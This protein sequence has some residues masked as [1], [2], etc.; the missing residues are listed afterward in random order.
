MRR[1]FRW[2]LTGLGVTGTAVALTAASALT[3]QAGAGA[4]AGAEQIMSYRVT[5][6]IH[7]DAS[8]VV[9]EQIVYDFGRYERHGL[10][11]EIPVLR[12]YS[13]QYDRYYP[14]DIRSVSSPDAPA[15]YTLERTADSVILKIG[16]PDRTVTGT[17]TYRLSYVVDGALN[18]FATNDELYWDAV[19][20]SWDV[21]IRQAAVR[22]T[23]PAPPLGSGCWA[24]P[25]GS[26][27]ACAQAQIEGRSATFAQPGLRPHEGLTIAVAL[28]K[29][30]VAAPHPVLRHRWSMEQAF[31]FTPVTLGTAGGLLA[32]LAILGAVVLTRGRRRENAGPGSGPP[33]GLAAPAIEAAPP[34]DL[35]PGLAGTL[36]DG[37]ANPQDVTGTIADLAVRGY[38]RIEETGQATPPDWRLV[39]LG[40]TGG[41]LEYEQILLD[42]LFQDATTDDAGEQ[43]VRLSDLSSSFAKQL[44]RAQDAL[45]KEVAARGW[46]TARPDRIR[47]RWAA[48]GTALLVA[49]VIAVIV[50]ANT[51]QFGLVPIPVA[52]AGLALLLGARWMPARTAGGT[53]MARRVAGFRSFIQADAVTRAIPAGE[54]EALYGYLPYA[55]AF[56]CTKQWADLTGT[57]AGTGQGP[58]WYRAREPFAP[59]SLSTLPRSAYYFTAMHH[60]ATT[61]GNWMSSNASASGSSAFSGGGF[62]GGG[63]GG[64]GG[65]SW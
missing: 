42:G 32:I 44:R 34:G 64:G 4:Q 59:G 17:H 37:V 10:I 1:L 39:R 18:G 53:A 35:R 16:N 8:I 30:A 13:K 52:L 61:T 3:A 65:G 7:R 26:D 25:A 5:I 27:T 23:A 47:R 55:I 15:Q 36:L 63:A 57:L 19:S 50:A 62:S 2:L 60:F 58:S 38:L 33:G 22:V 6:D 14:L 28:P 40:K 11:R 45:Y 49:G 24:G 51:S 20:P 29:G 31:A 9:T 21:P 48:I 54:P 41:L 12:T 56:G 43:S 46:F